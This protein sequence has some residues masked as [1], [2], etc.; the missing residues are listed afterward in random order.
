[1]KKSNGPDMFI[2]TALYHTQMRK[3]RRCKKKLVRKVGGKIRRQSKQEFEV[4]KCR[5][6]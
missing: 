3:Q 5:H 1:M 4:E 6:N 2:C